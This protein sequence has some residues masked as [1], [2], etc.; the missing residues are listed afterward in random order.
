M[1]YDINA[2]DDIEANLDK[3]V[4]MDLMIGHLIAT[5]R[6]QESELAELRKDKER[7]DK[8]ISL[9][10]ATPGT[11]ESV[12]FRPPMNGHGFRL[13]DHDAEGY[14][15]TVGEGATPRLAIDAA[16]LEAK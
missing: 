2:I 5:I 11:S 4:P 10:I 9:A 3:Y 12:Y 1:S 16:V 13:V 8:L 15:A 7:L 14:P 6:R